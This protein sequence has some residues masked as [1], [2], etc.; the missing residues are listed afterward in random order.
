[1]NDELRV[2]VVGAGPA[3]LYVADSLLLQNEVPVRVDVY[4]RLPTP[5]GL[6]RYG[7]APDHLKM[8]SLS[9]VLQRTLDDERVRFVGG[10]TVGREV[11]VDDLRAA[12]HAV[13]HTF[14]A[15]SDRRLGVPGE[16][17]DGSAS[18]TRFVHWYSGHPDVAADAFDLSA[19]SVAVIGVG[20]VAVD[21][22]R[23]LVK[24]V[25]ALRRTDIP[26][27]VLDVLSSSR[28]REVHVLGRRGPAHATFTSKELRELGELE[29]VDV[30]V[31]PAELELDEGAEQRAQ[32][33]PDVQ[34]NLSLLREWAERPRT[35]AAR[36]LHLHFWSRPLE[37]RGGERVEQVVVER[38]AVDE[39]GAVR[40]TGERWTLPAQ[41]VLRC[42]GYRGV[43][44]EGVPFDDGTCTVP[45]HEGRVLREGG[46]STGEY[47][48]GWIGRGPVGVLGTNRS[49]AESVV[50]RL[51]ADAPG[52]QRRDD[53]DIPARL[54][55]SGTVVVDGA[56]WAAID[57][58]EIALGAEQG[59]PRE[60]LATWDGLLE[61]AGLGAHGRG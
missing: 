32:A 61:A 60:K 53:V 18:A 24:D 19:E 38:T 46:V 52:L 36:S 28:V 51:L 23:I 40:A 35:G 42:V 21:V 50:E 16:E 6:L 34:R 5:F 8:K 55:S 10:V 44:V 57:A 43:P 22:S 1:M 37:L 49:D 47:V 39:S 15:S 30:V 33:D 58:A 59:R 4:D 9:K 7:V 2:A 26:S 14:G 17:L 29:G 12:Y 54:R 56:G 25:E 27:N 3:G 31:N 11:P 45:A 20:N 13:V 41:L 48:A